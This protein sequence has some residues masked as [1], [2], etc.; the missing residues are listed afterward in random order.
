MDDHGRITIPGYVPPAQPRPDAA[1]HVRDSRSGGAYAEAVRPALMLFTA[2]RDDPS[3]PDRAASN[4]SICPGG[5]SSSTAATCSRVQH[6]GPPPDPPAPGARR[7]H[8]KMK[9]SRAEDATM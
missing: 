8:N 9:Y 5:S 4:R 6:E 2:P 1:I 7:S 3:P